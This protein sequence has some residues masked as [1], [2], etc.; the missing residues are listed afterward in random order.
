[1][2]APVS[3]FILTFNEEANIAQAIASLENRVEAVF[4][5]DSGS[6]D[7]TVEIAESMGATVL[8][9][10]WPGYSKQVNWALENCP[11]P[12]EWVLRLDADE[13]ITPELADEF[14]QVLHSAP[15]NISA[16]Y[17]KRRFYFM[18]RWIRYGGYYPIWIVRLIRHGKAYCEDV[19]FNE[20]FI[21][22]EGEIS[23]LQQDMIHEDRKGLQDWLLKH[24][25]YARLESER[26]Q[27]EAV[28]P[29]NKREAATSSARKTWMRKNIF[30]RMPLFLRP[31]L[32]FIYRY[33]FRL[34]ILDGIPG[35]IFHFLQAFWLHFYVD[36]LLWESKHTRQ[37]IEK[38][39]PKQLP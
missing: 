22:T 25:K 21:V 1:M 18:D 9:N 19:A 36:S 33:I 32:Y 39:S 20:H 2:K 11:F 34:G 12:T 15:D 6:T 13:Y 30:L 14:A 3:V 29:D 28:E 7:R 17:I 27:R 10:P 16:Y 4:V 26:R 35:L 8:H 5:V 38:N 23:R 24:V 31:L 37:I